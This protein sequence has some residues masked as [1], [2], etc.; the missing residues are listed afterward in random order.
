MLLSSILVLF[1]LSQTNTASEN[2]H[3]PDTMQIATVDEVRAAM[4]PFPKWQKALDNSRAT[5]EEFIDV[6]KQPRGKVQKDFIVAAFSRNGDVF[7]PF[8]V[9]VE[10]IVG[11]RLIGKIVSNRLDVVES[12]PIEIDVSSI[13]DWRYIDT[14]ELFGARL[15]LTM[16]HD[17]TETVQ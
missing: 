14:W 16:F 10:R 3:G 9:S 1:M 2:E 12:N 6:L 8:G 4:K 5:L 15:F 17:Q 13:V 11:Q 7:V